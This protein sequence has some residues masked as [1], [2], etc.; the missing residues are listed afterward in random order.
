M[1]YHVSTPRFTLMPCSQL[2]KY[3][4]R[5]INNDFWLSWQH[6]L[7]TPVVAEE[8]YRTWRT[9]R[10]LSTDIMTKNDISIAIVTPSSSCYACSSRLVLVLLCSLASTNH[11]ALSP[12][13]LFPSFLLH[14]SITFILPFLP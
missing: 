14:P 12:H 7:Y 1:S 2:V 3:I 13:Q 4:K 9:L 10:T 11:H 8:R 6:Q 5:N